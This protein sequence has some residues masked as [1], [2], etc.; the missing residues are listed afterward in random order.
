MAIAKRNYLLIV[1]GSIME[2]T[3]FNYV[4]PQYGFNVVK[5]QE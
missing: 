4:L 1:E 3:I 5:I 2:P